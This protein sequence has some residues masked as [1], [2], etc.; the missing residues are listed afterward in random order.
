MS[1]R[2]MFPVKIKL[3]ENGMSFY[4][5]RKETIQAWYDKFGNHLEEIQ[6]RI[7]IKTLARRRK[8]PEWKRAYEVIES[9]LEESDGVT[10][11]TSCAACALSMLAHANSPSS[12]LYGNV[13]DVWN[14]DDN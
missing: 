1:I 6:Q 7:L 2:D 14:E 11:V 12:F 4:G 10:S 13:P 5:N 9:I 3:D 8:F